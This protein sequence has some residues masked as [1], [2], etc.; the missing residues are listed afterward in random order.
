MNLPLQIDDMWLGGSSGYLPEKEA[1]EREKELIRNNLYESIGQAI[2]LYWDSGTQSG[3]NYRIK[4][5]SEAKPI[6]N[7]PLSPSDPTHGEVMIYIHPDKLK[8]NGVIPNDAVIILHDPYVS[9]ELDKGGSLGASY[10]IV[11]PKYES[12]GLPSYQIAATWISRHPNGVDGYNDVFEKLIQFYGN[13]IRGVWYEANRG[14][15]FRGHMIKKHK[16]SLLCVRPQFEQGQFIYSRNATQTG[17]MVSNRISEEER[18]KILEENLINPNYEDPIFDQCY[19]AFPFECL[20]AVQRALKEETEVLVKRSRLIR[21]T[22]LTLDSTDENGKPI[23]GTATQINILQKDAPKVYEQYEKLKE[24]FI[25]EK[26]SMKGKGGAKL[27]KTEQG[28]FWN[29]NQK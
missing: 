20:T 10:V 13:P 18:R 4:P 8:I 22:D 27:S 15:R 12:F 3:V 2:E 29:V 6:Y 14:D 21:D 19:N 7:W 26:Q 5:L 16:A 17:Y 11:N 23:K 1:E 28:Q 25:A 9:D 24:K